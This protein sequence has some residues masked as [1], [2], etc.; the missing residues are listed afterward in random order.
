M[1]RTDVAANV[2]PASKTETVH[3]LTLV[4]YTP[5]EIAVA[6][7]ALVFEHLLLL[8]YGDVSRYRSDYFHDARWLAQ[9]LNTVPF[10]FVYKWSESGTSIADTTSNLL[11]PEPGYRVAL[12]TLRLADNCVLLDIVRL[13]EA[14]VPPRAGSWSPT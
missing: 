10:S 2:D 4:G 14:G 9:H 7:R 6:S 3:L 1:S 8:S 13:D 11:R 5:T 12:V